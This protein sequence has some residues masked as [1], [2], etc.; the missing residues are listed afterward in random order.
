MK[1]VNYDIHAV[2]SCVVYG[3]YGICKETLLS[4]FP[5]PPGGERGEGAGHALARCIAGVDAAPS[6]HLLTPL[7]LPPYPRGDGGHGV[8]AWRSLSAEVC[9]QLLTH[10]CPVLPDNQPQVVETDARVAEIHA[11]AEVFDTKAETSFKY[12]QARGSKCWMSPALPS[13]HRHYPPS[14]L[15]AVRCAA[16]S[17]HTPL[18]PALPHC[19]QVC[20]ACANIFGEYGPGAAQQHTHSTACSSSSSSSKDDL[21]LLLLLMPPP[22]PLH[23]PRQQRGGQRGGAPDSHLPGAA[24]G[25]GGGICGCDCLVCDPQTTASERGPCAFICF[26]G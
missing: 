23:S 17:S 9:S 26:S 20:T 18:C 3:T 19:P 6:Q 5:H 11:S 1:G 2:G 24:R 12:L 15:A 25:G 14:G 13:L 7:F 16:A 22:P 10:I 21:G 4:L 8:V